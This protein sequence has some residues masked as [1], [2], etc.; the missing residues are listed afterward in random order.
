MVR[1][2]ADLLQQDGGPAMYEVPFAGFTDQRGTKASGQGFSNACK[3]VTASGLQGTLGLMIPFGV[4]AGG[5][6]DKSFPAL[7][8]TSPAATTRIP[9]RNATAPLMTGW[10]LPTGIRPRWTEK[11]LKT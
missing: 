7:I 8:H 10:Q 1:H 3:I 2:A 4:L 11:S 9:A 6:C 5:G